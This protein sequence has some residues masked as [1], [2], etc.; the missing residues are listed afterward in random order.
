MD[1]LFSIEE[2]LTYISKIEQLQLIAHARYIGSMKFHNERT[3]EGYTSDEIYAV[4]EALVKRFLETETR[5]P[6]MM[7]GGVID[8]QELADSLD[9]E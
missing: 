6:A 2:W 5:V 9:D 8:Y 1:N 7:D 4:H 3:E